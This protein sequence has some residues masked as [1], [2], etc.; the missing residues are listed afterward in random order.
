MTQVG[1]RITE[2]QFDRMAAPFQMDLVAYYNLILED[3]TKLLT[4][5]EESGQTPE[6]FIQ[7]VQELLS[8]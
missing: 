6:E 2:D 1:S 4:E 5:A 7:K 8:D 3:M